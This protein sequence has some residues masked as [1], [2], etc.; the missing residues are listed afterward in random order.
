MQSISDRSLHLEKFGLNVSLVPDEKVTNKLS[1]RWSLKVTPAARITPEARAY[2][3]AHRAAML[4][5]L[6][7]DD[8]D[9]DCMS[10]PHWCGELVSK[11]WKGRIKTAGGCSKGHR[12]WR[13]SNVRGYCLYYDW[14]FVGGCLGPLRE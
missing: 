11:D 2:I 6:I 5:K 12:P 7:G 9:H 3:R 13:V 14:H 10:C 1:F 8:A 4:A